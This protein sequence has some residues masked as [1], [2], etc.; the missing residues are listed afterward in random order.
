MLNINIDKINISLTILKMV[1]FLEIV[2]SQKKLYLNEVVRILT[3]HPVSCIVTELGGAAEKNL[4]LGKYRVA[5][6]VLG[7]V[8]NIKTIL[9][10]VES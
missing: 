7:L 2:R 1:K 3:G 10:I 9:I 4:K 8:A 6:S 5:H